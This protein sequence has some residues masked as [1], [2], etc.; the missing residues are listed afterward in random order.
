MT[1][2][3]TVYTGQYRTRKWQCSLKKKTVN[4]ITYLKPRCR[5][6]S[7][8]GGIEKSNLITSSRLHFLLKVI[9]CCNTA[10]IW[11]QVT[12]SFKNLRLLE[13][14][15]RPY[16]PLQADSSEFHVTVLG[17][18]RLQCIRALLWHDAGQRGLVRHRLKS[19]SL[20]GDER[21]GAFPQTP[22]NWT[23]TPQSHWPSRFKSVCFLSASKQKKVHNIEATELLWN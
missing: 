23:T 3:S 22:S 13:L 4:Q 12:C 16:R 10:A 1:Y 8:W 21:G 6:G 9:P 14:R 19:W 18:E 5:Q 7:K 15:A 17:R 11:W 20:W 2:T